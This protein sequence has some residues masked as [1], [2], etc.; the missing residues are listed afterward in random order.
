MSISVAG[1]SASADSSSANDGGSYSNALKS[2]ASIGLASV[3][4][5]ALGI[6]RTKCVALLLGPA[7]VGLIGTYTSILSVAG[8]LAGMGI[9]S[10]GVRHIAEAAGQADVQRIAAAANA[11]RW[12]TRVLG[13]AG[14]F[15]TFLFAPLLSEWTF[16][17]HDH[18]MALRIL[19][20]TVF[21]TCLSGGQVALLQGLRRIGDL[22]RVNIVGSLVGTFVGVPLVWFW[23]M[24]AI[25][26]LL[27]CVPA[28]A[29]LSSWFFVRRVPVPRVHLSWA[30]VLRECRPLLGLGFAMMAS[31]LLSVLVGYF[32][33]LVV[34]R[35]LGIEAAGQYQAAA[36]LSLMYVG[37]VL[38]AMGTDFYPRLTAA[39]HDA[40][41]MHRV[42]NEQTEISILLAAP[43]I[44]ATLTLAP[45]IIRVF[46]SRAF[47]D[48]VEVLQWQ[49]LGVALRV[50]SWPLGYAI[51]AQGRGV[52]YFCTELFANLLHASLIWVCIDSNGLAGTGQAFAGMYAAYWAV[53]YWVVRRNTGLHYGREI[54]WLIVISF[55]SCLATFAAMRLMPW[56]AGLAIGAVMTSVVGVYSLNMLARRAPGL[57][58]IR[59]WR[60]LLSGLRSNP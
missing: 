48:A 25:V 7:G 13:L 46:Y 14:A 12:A 39:C 47:G 4:H 34:L 19:A 60:K 41:A 24:D 2:T 59:W 9:T 52:L 45:L 54:R 57:K 5:A 1:K 33:R 18:S 30:E 35:K 49:T 44:L 11:L 50:V 28:A 16:G 55:V 40:N 32:L 37:F 42:L 23:G 3:I 17:N 56:V 26:P 8:T 38:G 15:L 36:T 22:V 10:S 31:A 29:V 51:L 27:V 53:V 21:F 6:V 43:G 20:V 58:P